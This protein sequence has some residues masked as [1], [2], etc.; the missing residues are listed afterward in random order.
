MEGEGEEDNSNSCPQGNAE[1]QD[2]LEEIS[3]QC[4]ELTQTPGQSQMLIPGQYAL[5]FSR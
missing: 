1:S 4:D 5:C 3:S 2:N